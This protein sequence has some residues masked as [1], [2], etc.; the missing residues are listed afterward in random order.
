MALT[1][2]Q[3]QLIL[4]E[5][6]DVAADKYYS[7]NVGE[8]YSK[9]GQKEGFNLNPQRVYS[10]ANIQNANTTPAQAPDD[11]LGIRKSIQEELGIPQLN[12]DYQKAYTDYLNYQSS[13]ESQQ[14]ALE[15]QTG[16]GLN[17]IRGQQAEAQRLGAQTVASKARGLEA[18]G[19]RLT[20]ARQEAQDVFGIRSQEVQWKRNLILEN[21]QAGITFGDSLD[22]MA[23][24]I[25]NA[26]QL[27]KIESLKLQYPQ[28][29]SKITSKN[30]DKALAQLGKGLTKSQLKEQYAKIYGVAP[31]GLSTKAMEKK[32]KKYF[33][34]ELSYS[35][36][37]RDIEMQSIRE[38]LKKK[39]LGETDII[40]NDSMEDLLKQ[41]AQATGKPTDAT[42]GVV[43]DYG[44][45][46]PGQNQSYATP[47]VD[48]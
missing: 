44:D 47:G 1:S 40:D 27:Q 6:P 28:L 41:Y 16:V 34:E 32:I 39:Q 35:K 13:L 38:S 23:S 21:P 4:T 7:K 15:G 9:Y 20:A 11:L 29:A 42:G 10:S 3:E 36:E 30:L 26:N 12:T 48:Y 18:L 45:L 17:V 5:R 22:S 24:K 46:Y 25:Q 43:T 19:S 2:E 33:K 8:W 37:K 14:N 31:K